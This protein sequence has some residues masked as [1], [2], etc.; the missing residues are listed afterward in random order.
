MIIA[1][2]STL[3]AMVTIAKLNELERAIPVLQ[4]LVV[5]HWTEPLRP[6]V[7]SLPDTHLTIAPR[8]TTERI[9]ALPVTF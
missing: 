9:N 4:R 2:K 1:R 8:V 6:T 5:Q 3:I 7:V